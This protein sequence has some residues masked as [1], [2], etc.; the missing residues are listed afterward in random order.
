M[1]EEE[2][3]R[4]ESVT[5]VGVAEAGGPVP[6][7]APEKR[8]VKVGVKEDVD[9]MRRRIKSLISRAL[10]VGLNTPAS[11]IVEDVVKK[12]GVVDEKWVHYTTVQVQNN[13]SKEL[14]ARVPKSE[15]VVFIPHCLRNAK[16]CRAE[17]DEDGYH[18]RK[19]GACVIAKIT[20]ECEKRGMKWYMVGGGSQVV[21]IAARIKPKAIVGVACYKEIQ[22]ASDAF[23]G[24]SAPLHAVML[25]KSGC[26]NTEVDLNELIEALDA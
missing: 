18:C 14:F 22:L 10:M 12:T 26:V 15:R 21:N 7:A 17:V 23:K 8:E 5:V 25:R 13:I 4:E 24:N 6:A 3:L 1:A 20:A 2:I 16:A 19:C 11:T 9:D